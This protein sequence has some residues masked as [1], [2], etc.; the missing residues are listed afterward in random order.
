MFIGFLVILEIVLVIFT[1][2][3]PSFTDKIPFFGKLAA[4]LTW[5]C[6]ILGIVCLVFLGIKAYKELRGIIHKSKGDGE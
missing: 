2:V 5:I 6:V 4:P 3:A 1:A